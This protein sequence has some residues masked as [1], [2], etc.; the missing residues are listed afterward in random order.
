MLWQKPRKHIH[1]LRYNSAKKAIM[2]NVPSA[3]KKENDAAAFPPFE[4]D[5]STCLSGP[6]IDCIKTHCK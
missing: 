6:L 5:W 2:P 3:H 4:S 1:K